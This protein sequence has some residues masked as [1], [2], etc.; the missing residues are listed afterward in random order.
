[1]ENNGTQ[2]YFARRMAIMAKLA[3]ICEQVTA[4][5]PEMGTDDKR[6]F[7]KAVS[8]IMFGPPEYTADH[9]TSQ[10]HSPRAQSLRAM[11]VDAMRG[12]A[13]IRIRDIVALCQGENY[14]YVA[15][16]LGRMCAKGEAVR[17]SSGLYQLRE[18]RG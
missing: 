3:P 18:Q 2:S 4:I 11:I 1:M 12:K 13:P 15:Q 10:M 14:G 16:L 17:V 8:E 9:R 6:D 7:V 5:A